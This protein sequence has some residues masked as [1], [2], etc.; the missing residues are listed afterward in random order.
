MRSIKWEVTILC[1]LIVVV[2]AF[3]IKWPISW[4]PK[5]RIN[6][7]PTPQSSEQPLSGGSVLL[8]TTNNAA[9]DQIDTRLNQKEVIY[10]VVG[11]KEIIA[12]PDNRLPKLGLTKFI[13]DS[14]PFYL[15]VDKGEPFAVGISPSLGKD[16][17]TLYSDG[18]VIKDKESESSFDPKTGKA[19]SGANIDKQLNIFG[20]R[21]TYWSAW[22]KVF[23]ETS[24]WDDSMAEPSS[25]VLTP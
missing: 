15:Y 16:T 17:L 2:I 12:F 9:L 11:S 24:I 4:P 23:P 19:L 13:L 5:W 20:V 21:K 10:G 22:S 8:D 1:L 14:I 18:E 6:V 25:P 3:L 7:H